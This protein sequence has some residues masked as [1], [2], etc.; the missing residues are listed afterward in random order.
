MFSVLRRLFAPDRYPLP[1]EGPPPPPHRDDPIEVL[2]ERARKLAKHA[3]EVD[4]CRS[5]YARLS[6][7][8]H[9]TFAFTSVNVALLLYSTWVESIPGEYYGMLLV[10]LSLFMSTCSKRL[11]K[12]P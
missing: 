10:F 7:W 5:W 8:H 6:G 1:R 9:A 3:I 4:R 12:L 11:V 2:E